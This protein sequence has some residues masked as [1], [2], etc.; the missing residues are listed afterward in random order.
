[1]R[2]RNPRLCAAVAGSTRCPSHWEAA[3]NAIDLELNSDVEMAKTWRHIEDA[4]K[5]LKPTFLYVSCP[6]SKSSSKCKCFT[7]RP[8]RRTSFKAA[9]P[10]L[11]CLST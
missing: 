2:N 10:I 4:M 7:L 6:A 1:M 8:R 5:L 11:I 9:I 3:Q